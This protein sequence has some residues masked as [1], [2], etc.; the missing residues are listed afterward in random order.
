MTG[1]YGGQER[2]PQTRRRVTHR[3]AAAGTRSA[4][5]LP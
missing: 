1:P 5:C 2:H 4:V 3:A